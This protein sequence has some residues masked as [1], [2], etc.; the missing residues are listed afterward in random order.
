MSFKACRS[1]L[2]N[3]RPSYVFQP[4]LTDYWFETML[5]KSGWMAV[6]ATT[7]F[8]WSPTPTM[9][10]RA[11]LQKMAGKAAKDPK[12]MGMWGKQLE[13]VRHATRM[14]AHTNDGSSHE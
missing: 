4:I 14:T 1:H 6:A 9:K 7:K 13:A 10:Q 11:Q 2:G 3:R 12:N 5:T 8:G